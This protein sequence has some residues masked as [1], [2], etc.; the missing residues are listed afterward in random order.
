MKSYKDL[1]EEIGEFTKPTYQELLSTIEW[2][3]RRESITSRDEYTCTKCKR[4][5]HREMTTEEKELHLKALIQQYEINLAN[6]EK[7]ED[8]KERKIPIGKNSGRYMIFSNKP[9]HPSKNTT[10]SYFVKNVPPVK[11][12]VH[13]LGYVK[14]KLPW[15]YP[16]EWLTTLCSECH[17]KVHFGDKETLPQQIKVYTSFTKKQE[18]FAPKCT[19]CNGH[20]YIQEYKQVQGGICFDCWGYGMQWE[21]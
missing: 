16:D 7:D 8:N 13:H 5:T 12:E 10:I 4:G 1:L 6:W 15:E 18:Y 19:K 20:G 2:F 14:G 21:P 9:V 17:H 3:N 11:F